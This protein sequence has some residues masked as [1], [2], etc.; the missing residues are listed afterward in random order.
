MEP[1]RKAEKVETEEE[2]MMEVPDL[3]GV[4]IM[5]V[6]RMSLLH[7]EASILKQLISSRTTDQDVLILYLQ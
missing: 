2:D 4:I 7:L 3:D 1:D 6:L 5:R